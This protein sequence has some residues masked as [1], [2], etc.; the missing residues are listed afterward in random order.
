MADRP[1]MAIIDPNRSVALD[2]A[3]GSG[4]SVVVAVD[5]D[6]AEHWGVVHR[7][8]YGIPTLGFSRAVPEHEQL[9]EWRIAE[10]SDPTMRW[11]M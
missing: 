3:G 2:S 1:Q 10:P 9:G 5:S 6:G 11:P 7:A 8:A 4:L